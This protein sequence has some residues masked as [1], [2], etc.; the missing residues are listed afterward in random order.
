MVLI[1]P[2]IGNKLYKLEFDLIEEASNNGDVQF[3][4]EVVLKGL[5]KNRRISRK[6]SNA[7]ELVPVVAG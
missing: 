6:V 5:F 7:V 2:T 3:M 1:K 4:G